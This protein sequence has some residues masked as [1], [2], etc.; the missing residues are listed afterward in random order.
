VYVRVV[1]VPFADVSTTSV[2][3]VNDLIAIARGAV[4][5]HVT[6]GCGIV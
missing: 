6:L 3:P 5:S 1:E 2:D 4:A